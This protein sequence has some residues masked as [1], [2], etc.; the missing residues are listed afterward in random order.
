MPDKVILSNQ[1][2]LRAKYKTSGERTIRRAVNDLIAADQQRGLKTQYV[3]VDDADGMKKLGGKAVSTADSARQNKQAVDAIYKAL[4]PD[5]LVILGAVDVIP[6]QD[7]MNPVFNPKKPDDDPDRTVPSDLPYACEAPYSRLCEN[8]TG[9]TRVVGRL[10]D[11]TGG[12]DPGY[13]AGLLTTAASAQQRPRPEYEAYLGISASVWRKSTALSL[14][15]IF[16]SSTDEQVCPPA[17]L[18][19]PA[20]LL[21]RRAHLI[22]CHGASR[23]PHFYGQEGDQYPVSYDAAE[24]ANQLSEGVVA[25]MECCYGAELYDPAKVPGQQPGMGNTYLLNKA[26]GYLGSTTIA[27]GPDDSNGWADLL[28]QHFLD[29]VLSGASL[30]RSLLQA[31]QKYVQDTATPVGP[32]DLKTLAQFTLLGDP[33][34]QAVEPPKAPA[35]SKAMLKIQSKALFAADRTGRI[36][37]R[38]DLMLNGLSLARTW[39]TVVSKA[40]GVVQGGMRKKLDTLAKELGMAK[41]SI[42]TFQ[43]RP[44]AGGRLP[45][46]KAMIARSPDVHAVHVMIQRRPTPE[47]RLNDLLAVVVHEAHGE[48]VLVRKGY[49]K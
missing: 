45:Q 39:P 35:I 17:A 8:F 44:T 5:Y 37:R 41:P 28:C 26:Y 7:L 19:W 49:G 24:L 6:H 32:I 20:T 4:A 1:S 23:D 47:Q 16:G 48:V 31:R 9:P 15:A 43:S 30:G 33:S 18:P 11:I 42:M 10:P 22:N 40:A 34:L 13:L 27:Y 12:T 14:Q 3:E 21:G 29:N 38:K 46:A 2:A 25:A 36:A